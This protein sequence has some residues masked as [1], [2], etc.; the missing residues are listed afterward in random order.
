[1]EKDEIKSSFNTALTI[2]ERL[3]F[4]WLSVMQNSSRDNF[5]E[6]NSALSAIGRELRHLMNKEQKEMHDNFFSI[7]EDLEGEFKK[8]MYFFQ[9][10]N[11]ERFGSYQLRREYDSDDYKRYRLFKQIFIEFDTFLREIQEKLDLGLAKREN[12]KR[13]IAS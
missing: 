2:N 9:P 12:P 3:A 10:M 5:P 6:W 13:A 4:G 1:M 11:D 8:K 7:L